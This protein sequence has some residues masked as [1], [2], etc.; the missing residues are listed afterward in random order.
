VVGLGGGKSLDAAK[1]VAMRKGI[2]LI[3]IPTV[4]SVDAYLSQAAAVRK[5]G[6]VTLIGNVEPEKIIVDSSVIR[7]APPRLNRAGAA[8]VY[9]SKTSLMDWK[10]AHDRSNEELDEDTVREV[11]AVLERLKS[12]SEQIRNVSARGVKT[13]VRLHS[14]LLAIQRPYSAQKK[15]WPGQGI[16]HIFS[17]ALESVTHRTFIHGEIVGAGCLV[18][19]M[20]HGG[21]AREVVEDLDSIGICFRPGDY[22]ISKREFARALSSMKRI[23]KAS[24]YR[25][26]ALDDFEF[27]GA[28]VDKMW[29]LLSNGS[30]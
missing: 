2:P 15:P 26:L 9:A 11:E 25:Y 5:A 29:K 3:L 6:A 7:G 13:L 1:Y 4:L 24:G 14:D 18:A 20:I 12:S 28:E 17:Y 23:A 22:G 30:E 10:V 27:T 8:D 19:T 16:E 21:D